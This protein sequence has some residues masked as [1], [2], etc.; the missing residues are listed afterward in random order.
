MVEDLRGYG[1]SWQKISEILEV[2]RWTLQ[3]RVGEMN[4]PNLREFSLISNDEL[5]ALIKEYMQSLVVHLVKFKTMS[6]TN[7][8]WILT[9]LATA[10]Y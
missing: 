6:T 3:R 5:D 2:S 7:G 4:L 1:Y 8:A 9:C 10:R